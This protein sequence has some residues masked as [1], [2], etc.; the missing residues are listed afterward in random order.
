MKNGAVGTSKVCNVLSSV[1]SAQTIR[2]TSRCV[3]TRLK[4]E[5]SK[6]IKQFRVFIEC[7]SNNNFINIFI[8]KLE[9]L[10]AYMR[11]YLLLEASILYINTVLLAEWENHMAFKFKTKTF[12]VLSP[13]P[14][15]KQTFYS[16][17][18]FQFISALITTNIKTRQQIKKCI[19]H[20][21]INCAL[22][23]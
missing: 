4:V 7:G 20:K 21:L 3:W 14:Y 10:Y 17:L 19:F 23:R 16:N 5:I 1:L 9:I 15:S 6:I 11:N 18:K 8:P 12:Q 22:T 2:R 13:L